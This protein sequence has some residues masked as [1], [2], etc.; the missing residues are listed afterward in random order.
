M[1][2]RPSGNALE[3]VP[4]V[5]GFVSHQD[6]QLVTPGLGFGQRPRD[7]RS[8]DAAR[9]ERRLDRERTEQQRL[10]VADADGGQPHRTDHERADARGE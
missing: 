6:D 3:T 1:T 5:I 7:Q 9:T 4:S 2:A 10:G 8:A